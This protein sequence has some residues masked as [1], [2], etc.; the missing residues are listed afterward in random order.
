M[1]FHGNYNGF[2]LC[3]LITRGRSKDIQCHRF[4]KLSNHQIKCE[5]TRSG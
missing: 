2:G 5:A 3:C 1:G 4:S